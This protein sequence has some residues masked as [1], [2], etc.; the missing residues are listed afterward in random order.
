MANY[1]CG[2]KLDIVVTFIKL[3]F[4]YVTILSLEIEYIPYNI[5][6]FKDYSR[7]PA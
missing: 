3:V 6:H 5:R 2:I 1:P 7:C 4:H